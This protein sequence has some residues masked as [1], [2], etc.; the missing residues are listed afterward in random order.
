MFKYLFKRDNLL[1]TIM[2][3]VLMGMLALIPVNTHVLDPIKLAL[4]DFDY[5]DLAYSQMHKNRHSGVDTGIVVINIGNA[6][7]EAIAGMIAAVARANPLAIGVD[8]TF[9][10][11][12][13]PST[14]S[15]LAQQF[16]THSN[17][18]LAYNYHADAAQHTEEFLVPLAKTK[19]FANFVGEEGGTIRHFLP[20]AGNHA[21]A[22][23]AA[24]IAQ[25]AYPDAY[26]KLSKKSSGSLEIHYTRRADKYMVIEGSALQ[27]TGVGAALQ[28][29]LVLLGYVATNPADIEDKHFTPLNSKAVGKS[30]PDMDGVFVHANILG[31]IRD[32][33][34]IHKSPLWLNWLLAFVLCWLHM[35]FFI[36]YFLDRHLWFHLVAKLA[37]LLSAVLFVYLGLYLFYQFDAK[38]NL[39]PTFVAIVLAVDVLYFYEA[40]CNWLHKKYGIQSIF[41]QEHHHH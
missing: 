13:E 41:V 5:N 31:M 35:S 21:Y 39:S 14:D 7:R 36:K 4:Q 37:Q 10:Q 17:I 8:V 3:F 20:F 23:F 16:A 24:A 6:G 19:G 28:G 27:E 1:A 33:N 25:Q 22:S 38:L 29:K 15:L 40:I 26:N 11:P 9:T 34:Y 30:V 18:V 2:V 32:G 12:K